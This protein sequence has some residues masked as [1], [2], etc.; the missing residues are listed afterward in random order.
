MIVKDFG[1]TQAGNASN[2]NQS[3]SD[4]D[5]VDEQLSTFLKERWELAHQK[6]VISIVY[7]IDR[8]FVNKRLLESIT[9]ALAQVATAQGRTVRAKK[10][11]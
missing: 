11:N 8:F 9:I 5:D 6:L 3:D 4:D 10:R 7:D 2:G 1:E